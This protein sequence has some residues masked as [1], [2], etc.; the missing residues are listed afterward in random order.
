MGIFPPPLRHRI[1][2]FFD[3]L[4]LCRKITS[5]I[6]S[7]R[8]KTAFWCRKTLSFGFLAVFP[9]F[10]FVSPWLQFCLRMPPFL[11]VFDFFTVF[12]PRFT[13]SPAPLLVL[14][15]PLVSLVEHL[16]LFPNEPARLVPPLFLMKLLSAYAPFIVTAP[17]PFLSRLASVTCTLL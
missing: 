8:S 17:H 2:F 4:L 9:S 3:N 16:F 14:T 12:F 13:E 15:Q 1:F 11:V 10:A 6:L 7:L 5:K